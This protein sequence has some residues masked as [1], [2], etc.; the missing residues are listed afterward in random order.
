MARSSSG[1]VGFYLL[2]ARHHRRR[3]LP[4]LLRDPHQLQNG[5][6]AV[7]GRLLAEGRSRSTTTSR[8]SPRATSRATS[9]TRCSSRPRSSFLS[10]LLGVTAAYA[11]GARPLPRPLACSCF[12]ILSVSMFPQLAVLAGLFE[13][14]R[15]VGLYQHALRADLLLH[16]LHAAL[17]G[18]GADHLHARPADRDRGGGDRRRRHAR[19]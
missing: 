3:G 11:L 18:V 12:T 1:N 7:R 13:L 4:V 16:D 14:V 17:H 19:G 5:H 8:S 15:T 2:V 10:L 6:R 9:S